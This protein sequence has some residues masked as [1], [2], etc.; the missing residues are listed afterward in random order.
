MAAVKVIAYCT[1]AVLSGEAVN[2]IAGP[3]LDLL[4]VTDTIPVR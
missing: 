4:V 3:S 2:R 1:H